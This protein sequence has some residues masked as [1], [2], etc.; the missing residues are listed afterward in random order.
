MASA[1]ASPPEVVR[2]AQKDDYY[3]GGLRSAAGS[4]LHSLAGARKWLEWRKEL[5]LLSD[6]AYFGLTTLAGYQTLGEEYV[7][8]VQV[9]PSR[10]QVPQRLRRGVL[11]ALH[12]VLPYVLDKALLHLEQELQADGNGAR[13]APGASRGRSGARRWVHRQ[14]AA[15]PEPQRR[16]LLRAVLVLRQGLG[17]LHRLHVAWFYIHGAFYHLAKRLTGVTYEPHGGE[18]CVP[19]LAVHPVPGGAQALDGHALRPPVLLG[20]HH[21]VVRHQDGVSPVQG[22]VPS[23]E[24]GLPAALPVTGQTEPPQPLRSARHSPHRRGDQGARPHPV[25]QVPFLPE[26]LLRL[27]REGETQSMDMRHLDWLP[28][29]WAPTGPR[30]NLKP[31]YMSLIRLE[32]MTIQSVGRSSN[33]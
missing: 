32:P 33:R 25:R 9:D 31:R 13:P 29:T 20:V 30:S 7:G 12:T 11:V 24:A 1:A 8:L 14:V 6:V 3:R 21:P 28:L 10:S 26:D 18:S 2:A 5:E 23:P 15:L 17:C 19:E 16:A 27:W 22:E 4:A